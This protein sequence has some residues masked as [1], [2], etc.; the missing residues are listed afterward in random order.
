MVDVRKFLGLLLGRRL[1]PEMQEPVVQLQPAETAAA[2]GLTAR[3][4]WVIGFESVLPGMRGYVTLPTGPGQSMTVHFGAI[5]VGELWNRLGS[6]AEARDNWPFAGPGTFVGQVALEGPGWDLQAVFGVPGPGVEYH[7]GRRDSQ[8][9]VTGATE[10][11]RLA[12]ALWLWPDYDAVVG[13]LTLHPY[14]LWGH[15]A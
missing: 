12:Q 9:R 4:P 13:Y 8:G 6:L 1:P 5:T 11:Q 10:W 3:A 15:E 2:H 14:A 7:A